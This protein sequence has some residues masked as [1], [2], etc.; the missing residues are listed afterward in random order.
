MSEFIQVVVILK[1]HVERAHTGTPFPSPLSHSQSTSLALF[2]CAFFLHHSER[3]NEVA[4]LSAK[5][6]RLA[7]LLAIVQVG[8]LQGVSVTIA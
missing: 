5:V 1:A 7:L 2:R 8:W 3:T 4:M 6:E